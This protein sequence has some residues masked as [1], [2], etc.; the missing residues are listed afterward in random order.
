[1]LYCRPHA[2][3]SGSRPLRR[4]RKDCQEVSQTSLPSA[5]AQKVEI[6]ARNAC[7][8]PHSLPDCWPHSLSSPCSACLGLPCLVCPLVR[9]STGAG[10][11]TLRR[12]IAPAHP[13]RTLKRPAIIF[14]MSLVKSREWHL[15]NITLR[16]LG[17]AANCGRAG[18]G[19][20]HTTHTQHTTHTRKNTHTTHTVAGAGSGRGV[21]AGGIS[22]A[23]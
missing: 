1:M 13:P 23:A 18:S 10:L 2:K 17:A 14:A 3:V 12:R 15:A 7:A 22:Q 20:L 8:S 21:A 4:R 16:I 5:R 19:H 9:S 11:T 6:V